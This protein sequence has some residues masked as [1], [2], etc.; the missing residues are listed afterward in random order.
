MKSY[1]IPIR[2]AK[3]NQK[4]MTLSKADKDVRI[5]MTHTSLVGNIKW[6]KPSGKQV[7]RY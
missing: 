4:T 7:V 5:W 2:M 6:Y 1:H 3:I